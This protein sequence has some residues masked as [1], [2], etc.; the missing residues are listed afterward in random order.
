MHTSITQNVLQAR[1]R[2]RGAQSILTTFLP[3]NAMLISPNRSSDIAGM[4]C[5]HFCG[6]FAS[7]S[8]LSVTPVTALLPRFSTTPSVGYNE[9][10][11]PP[12]VRRTASSTR[13]PKATTRRFMNHSCQPNCE[14]QKWTVNGDTRVGLFAVCDIPA[15]EHPVIIITIVIIVFI[16]VI[17]TIVLLKFIYLFLPVFGAPTAPRAFELLTRFKRS[18]F[19]TDLRQCSCISDSS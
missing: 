3:C 9:G 12:S 19:S 16:S 15:G 8:A 1:P 6:A 11:F 7:P 2:P 13:A 4:F 18:Q 10:F 14:T 17:A 5:V